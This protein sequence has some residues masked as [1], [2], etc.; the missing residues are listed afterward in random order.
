MRYML[1]MRDSEE[2][3][4]AAKEQDFEQ[5]INAMGAY[6]EAMI[7]AGVLLAGEGLADPA[8]GVVVDFDAEEPVVTD[9]PYGETR[10]LFNGFWIIQVSSRE[11]AVEWARR[12]PLGPGSTLEVRRVQ[13]VEDFADYADNEY[14]RKEAEWRRQLGTE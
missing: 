10:E 4:Q 11:E 12:A 3:V 9:G 2:A 13:E 6:N 7:K 14:I 8:E 5:V 1:V